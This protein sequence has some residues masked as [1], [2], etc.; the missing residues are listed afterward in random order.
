MLDKFIKIYDAFMWLL[1]SITLWVMLVII[2]M[3]LAGKAELNIST[4]LFS[5]GEK[6]THDCNLAASE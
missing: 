2:S 4:P 5:I 6:V 3:I 1:G